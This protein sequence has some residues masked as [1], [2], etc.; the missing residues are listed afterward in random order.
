MYGSAGSNV[1]ILNA[2]LMK[3]ET[4]FSRFTAFLLLGLSMLILYKAK[5]LGSGRHYRVN[6]SPLVS[7]DHSRT[8]GR[9]GAEGSSSV[10]SWAFVPENDRRSIHVNYL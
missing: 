10:C 4:G 7:S 1:L 3:I 6:G 5:F 9:T 2:T 8:D